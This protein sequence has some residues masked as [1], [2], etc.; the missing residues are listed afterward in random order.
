MSATNVARAGKQGNI[1]VGN[2]VSSFAR[3]FSNSH[4]VAIF[5]SFSF[6]FF[7]K[8]IFLQRAFANFIIAFSVRLVGLYCIACKRL[9]TA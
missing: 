3:T 7:P 5:A 8:S 4:R 2:N 6:V 9:C 1:C